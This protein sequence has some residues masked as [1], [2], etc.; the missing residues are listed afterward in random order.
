MSKKGNL[1]LNELSEGMKRAYG[2]PIEVAGNA[3]KSGIDTGLEGIQSG[4]KR[5]RRKRT[6]EEQFIIT[7]TSSIVALLGA[8]VIFINNDFV[9]GFILLIVA[10]IITLLPPRTPKETQV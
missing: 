1:P 6:R 8:Y 3:I 4:Q 9:S 7:I 5:M 2:E 10:V